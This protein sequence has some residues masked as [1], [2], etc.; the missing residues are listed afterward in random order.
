MVA[1]ASGLGLHT[2]AK[3]LP[4][5]PQIREIPGR[6]AWQPSVV[7]LDSSLVFTP[8]DEGNLL[9]RRLEQNTAR[10][11]SAHLA[12]SASRFYGIERYEMS[13]VQCALTGADAGLTLG[14]IAGALGMTAGLWDE[15]TAWYLGGAAAALGTLWGASMADEPKFRVRIRWDDSD[16]RP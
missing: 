15:R 4:G 13:K 7:R 14:L 8:L 10:S 9:S 6:A 1:G 12:V 11:L 16:R 3:V 2:S 5:A